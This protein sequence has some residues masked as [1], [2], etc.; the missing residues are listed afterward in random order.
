MHVKTGYLTLLGALHLLFPL[1]PSYAQSL[2]PTLD[3]D[4]AQTIIEACKRKALENDW[5]MAIA[6][7]DDRAT[8]L[9]F[10]RMDGVKTGNVRIA[11]LKA[12]AAASYGRPTKLW[13]ERAEKN[14]AYLG[15]PAFPGFGGGEAIFARDGTLLG[16][17][18]VSGSSD[19][20]DSACA[21]AGILAAELQFQTN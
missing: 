2:R 14:P 9:A 13:A 15:L 6:I 20:N 21:Q 16:G 18:G 10:L 11:L 5:K 17:V 8:L 1:Q 19:S 4:A 12:E 3:S 7:Y